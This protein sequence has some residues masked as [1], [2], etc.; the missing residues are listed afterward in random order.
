MAEDQDQ[1]PQQPP[2]GNPLLEKAG[3]VVTL[4]GAIALA[5]VAVDTLRGPRQQER[6]ADERAE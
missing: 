6:Q 2:A 4:L 5:W 3:A 1:Q